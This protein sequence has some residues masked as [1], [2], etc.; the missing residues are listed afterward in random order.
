MKIQ[1]KN[2][3]R[4]NF[5]LSLFISIILL[6]VSSGHALPTRLT[7]TLESNNIN[8]YSLDVVFL[9]DQSGS[10]TYPSPKGWLKPSDPS[11]LRLKAVKWAIDWLGDNVLS[12]CP[13]AVHRIGVISWGTTAQV[14]FVEHISPK[15]IN[16]WRS[17]RIRIKDQVKLQNLEFTKPDIA[18]G[19]AQKIFDQFDIDA[20]GDLPRK[21]VVIFLTDGIPYP[22]IS[23]GWVDQVDFDFPFDATL[24]QQEKCLAQALTPEDRNN[25]LGKVK[26]SAYTNSIYIWSILLNAN[27]GVEYSEYTSFL[28]DMQQ[29]ST[30]HGGRKVSIEHY[31]QIP[32]T[33]LNILTTLAGTKAVAV[34]CN[35]FSVDPYL[36][37][38]TLSIFKIN[39]DVPV[40]IS[41]KDGDHTYTI[42][43]KDVEGN[44]TWPLQFPGFS[45]KDYTSID[46]PETKSSIERYVFLRPHA[47]EWKISAPT[48][49]NCEGIQ[50]SFEP[51]DVDV[52]L[53][54]PLIMIPQYDLEPYYDQNSPV[55][56][57]YQLIDRGSQAPVEEEQNY[58]LDVTATVISPDGSKEDFH[59]EYNLSTKTFR[60]EAPLK[61]NVIGRYMLESKATASVKEE[62]DLVLFDG[63]KSYF[64]IAETLPFQ[65][66]ILEPQPGQI[67]SLH[68]GLT[69]NFSIVPIEFRV[70]L[71]DRDKNKINKIDPALIFKDPNLSLQGTVSS[72]KDEFPISFGLDPKHPDEFIGQVTSITEEGNYHLSVSVKNDEAYS[73][74]YRPDKKFA[75]MDFILRDTVWTR[76]VTYK[77]L[78]ITLLALIIAIII[79]I[80]LNR[81]NPV[82]GTLVFE[83]GETHIADISIGTGWNISRISRRTLQAYSSLGLKSLRA[84]KSREQLGCV[85]YS[86]VDTNGNPYSGTL[87]PESPTSFAGGMTVRYEPL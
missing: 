39:K 29:I 30:T 24:L 10:M 87:M 12:S 74:K 15:T 69:T 26:E 84:Q 51:L 85:D 11:G 19:E 54:S 20:L 22:P 25:C 1:H 53:I 81:N 68:G 42:T 56:I 71:T 34:D 52:K 17:E 62:N 83:V 78:G 8:C 50:A 86:A 40:E 7:N 70:V 63:E 27:Q 79:I 77:V 44:E 2:S 58:P 72:G 59:L 43:Q 60:S 65:I 41:Y 38:A 76:P 80:V 6:P 37:Q 49:S 64:E 13:D 21:K 5:F 36:Q 45:V 73:A 3:V 57:E 33:F 23:Q 82:T 28:Q 55:Y 48:S 75:E 67:Y 66:K 18:F 61:V 16:E 4:V 9:I 46:D 32:P 35:P 47:A 31:S 14:D